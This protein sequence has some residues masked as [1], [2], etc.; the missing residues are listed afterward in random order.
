MV[1][2]PASSVPR[3]W[4]DAVGPGFVV[5]AT[6]VG[7]GD[8]I[9]A[10]VAGQRFG[11][12]VLWVVVLGA[13]FKWVL[14]DGIA[15]WQLATGTTLIEGW[16][17]R[18]P[19][20]VGW[21]FMGFL[22]LWSF[23]VAAALASACGVAARSLWPV[24]P[25]PAWAAVHAAAGFALVWL[26]RYRLFERV[27][28]WLTAAMFV[29][30]IG[31]AVPLLEDGGGFASGLFVPTVPEGSAK[32]LLG[33]MGGV[34]GSVTLLCYGYWMRERGWS[35]R[36]AHRR[37]S[38]DTG[39][40]YGL[41]GI[42]GLAMIVIAAG[43]EPAD[44]SGNALILALA[45]RLGEILGPFGR[46]C[47]LVG[48]WCSVFTSLLGVWQGVP[49]LFADSLAQMRRR[50]VPEPAS[51]SATA[52]PRDGPAT[53]STAYR[54]FLGFLAFPPLLLLFYR[55]P[56]AIVVMYAIAGAFFMPF[57]AGVLLVMNNR[58]A[59]VGSLKNGPVINAL[60][61]LSLVLFAVLF[62][63]EAAESLARL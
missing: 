4:R 48:F 30:V 53:R 22:V 42:F 16:S 9:A 20:V 8:L 55:S 61:V 13:L 33:V 56:L 63:F 43:T 60:L 62:V 28:A 51:A 25:I 46:M 26:G 52:P 54:V 17:R 14:N 59:W 58:R 32:F 12:A 36:A 37:T 24:M 11:L 15:R 7:A 23:L 41:S 10:S 19:R 49:Y 6:G 57:L 40:A 1:D 31:C 47:F 2:T 39:V 21:Y 27:M 5:A 35:G 50:S 38:L 3:S 18:L 34:G 45:A 44:A 29:L